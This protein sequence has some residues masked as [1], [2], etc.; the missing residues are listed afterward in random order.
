MG[1]KHIIGVWGDS[2]LKGVVQDELRG[3]YRLLAD[4]CVNLFE[5]TRNIE[6]I[7]RARFGSTVTKGYEQLKK[8]LEGGLSCD[9]VLLE[10]GGNDCDFNWQAVSD[11]PLAPHQPHTPLPEFVRTL[12]D[13]VTLLRAHHIRPALMSL[14]PISGSRYLDAIVSRGPDR[15]RLLQFLGSEQQIYQYHEWYSLQVTRLA[16]RMRCAYAPVREAFLAHGRCQDLLCADGI[17]PNEAGHR[18][19]QQVF[20]D[21]HGQL[22]RRGNLTP[23]T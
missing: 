4:S 10:Y 2:V 7:N 16:G 8:A 22:T 14:P 11:D 15:Q 1:I 17:H 3:T 23:A 12:Q 5:K 9:L 18:L 19:M 13:M 21:L 20:S 6:V